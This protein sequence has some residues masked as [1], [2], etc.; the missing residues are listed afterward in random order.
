MKVEFDFDRCIL[1][2]ENLA[3]SWEHIIPEIIGGRLQARILCSRCNNDLGSK[4]I[5]KV[6]NDPSIRLAIRNLREEIPK[7][8][9]DIE[10]NQIYN[11]KGKNDNHIRLKYKNSKF[12]TIA[13]KKEDGS[14]ILDARKGIKNIAQMLRKE[15][16]SEHEIAS[17]IRSF[18][19]L[20]NN[21]IIRLSKTVRIVKW[22]IESTFFPH[23]QGPLLDEKV[24]ALIAYEFLSL[25]VGNLI[26][27]DKL[28]FIRDFIKEGKKSKKLVIEH[29][30]SR[31][32]VPYHKI[33]PELL[34]AEIIINIILF[35]WLVYKVHIKGVKLL[36]S[37][38]FVYLED[39]KSRK[40]LIAKS[41]DEAKQGIYYGF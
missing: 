16:L 13:H 20:E 32:Y 39:L 1:C 27:N 9:E 22:S 25:L 15:G 34:E 19:K 18:K 11:A 41:V 10:K 35:G 23:L 4:L 8:F 7:L 14:L 38:D 12:E 30:T 17:K 36:S 3:D 31:H 5:S 24:I 37:P 29:L 28:D 26:Y 40:T 21:R 2:T 6:K 33:Y